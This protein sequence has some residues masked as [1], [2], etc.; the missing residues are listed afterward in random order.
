MS[1]PCGLNIMP[2]GGAPCGNA[3]GFGPDEA[4]APGFEGLGGTGGRGGRDA[5]GL[6]VGG[7]ADVEDAAVLPDAMV[8]GLM[9]LEGVALGSALSDFSVLT[10]L[11]EDEDL[12]A[13]A[14]VA[15]AVGGR[16]G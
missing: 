7:P 6:E 13:G 2:G 3:G 15:P 16:N 11:V 4:L 10:A 14:G 8:A 12:E 9:L 1:G 5:T